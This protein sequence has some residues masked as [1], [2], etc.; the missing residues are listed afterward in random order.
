MLNLT[1]HAITLRSPDGSEKTIQPSGTVARV[2][3]A[4]QVIGT[5]AGLPVIE[6]QPGAVT[7][8]PDGG[9]PCIVSAMVLS[10]VPG[11]PH[12][13]APDTGGTAIRED[14][15]IIAVTRLVRA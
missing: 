8:L 9:T 15:Q 10:A 1:P 3:M 11:R 5:H 7:G 14:G 4:E 12:T 2:E 6:R 13:Y